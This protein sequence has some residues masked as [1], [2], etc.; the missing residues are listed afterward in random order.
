[1]EE[2]QKPTGLLEDV[3]QEQPAE[4]EDV[5]DD[6][7]PI[8]A[9]PAPIRFAGPPPRKMMRL[10]A[11]S[12]IHR[13]ASEC[14][15]K[16]SHFQR[17]YNSIEKYNEDLTMRFLFGNGLPLEKINDPH[18]R[19]FL[20]H[21]NPSRRPPES[22]NMTTKAN[23]EM[24]PALDYNR[25]NSPLSVSV[26]AIRKNDE[27]YL[28]ISVHYHDALGERQNSVHF[29][30]VIIADYEGKMIADRLRRVVDP[31]RALSVVITNL[32]SPNVKMIQMLASVA[33]FKNKFICFFSYLSNIARDVIGIDEL[34]HSLQLLRNYVDAIRKHPEVYTKFKR[35]QLESGSPTD[36]P[37]PEMSNDWMST[38]QFVATCSVLNDTFSRLGER[39]CMPE[40]LSAEQENEMAMLTDFLSV[41]CHVA[42]QLCSEDSCVSQVLH[43]MSV[44]NNAVEQTGIRA[45]RVKMREIFAKYFASISQGPIGD[46]YA[47]AALLDPRFGYSDGIF[48]ADDWISTQIKLSNGSIVDET[49]RR[50]VHQ[51]EQ[52]LQLYRKLMLKNRPTFD[53]RMTPGRWWMEMS[54][55]LP[56]MYRKWIEH[57]GP[58]AVSVDGKRFFARGGKLAHLF[59][60]LDEALHFKALLLAQSSQD[61]VGRGNA[62]HHVLDHL[63]DGPSTFRRLETEPDLEEGEEEIEEVIYPEDQIETEVKQ[64]PLDD[65]PETTTLS[66]PP[67]AAEDIKQER[68]IKI[69]EPDE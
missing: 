12:I 43:S 59:D 5:E 26:E 34:A 4:P 33:K 24:R 3:K 23:M 60:T 45:V 32:I 25:L 63:R 13:T 20:H 53:E 46:F 7:P 37:P 69:E 56:N 48:S 52:E 29:E 66:D 1:M 38:L 8:L 62:S 67:I 47:I 9:P 16:A 61:F 57:S 15:S 14:I 17:H 10:P 51:L 36:L 41:L 58:P 68:E 30:K 11:G 27:V 42:S 19:L 22:G 6:K 64:E 49:T 65:A 39:W 18:M 40:Y 50:K 2:E 54:D 35:L 55:E 21:L 44:V 28:T 31:K